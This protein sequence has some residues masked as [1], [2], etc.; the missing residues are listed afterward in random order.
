M[1]PVVAR[2]NL[3][4]GRRTVEASGDSE[5]TTLGRLHA[6]LYRLSALALP[7]MGTKRTGI[8]FR[9]AKPTAVPSLA[10]GNSERL[11]PFS[12]Q[13]DQTGDNSWVSCGVSPRRKPAFCLE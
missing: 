9:S 10:A 2:P 4:V 12:A 3:T 7:V 8:T 13:V 6:T 5:V 11:W 1:V